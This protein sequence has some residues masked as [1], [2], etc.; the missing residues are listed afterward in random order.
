MRIRWLIFLA[1]IERPLCDIFT[2][3]SPARIHEKNTRPY[4]PR[5]L[6]CRDQVSGHILIA[7]VASHESYAKEFPGKLLDC[8]EK[9]G[10]IPIA[11]R[12]RKEET[13]ELLAEVAKRLKIEAEITPFLPGLEEALRE[14][15]DSF[16]RPPGEKNR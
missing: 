2:T 5:L 11:I 4:F 9:F 8:M 7:H 12:T 16:G 3:Y 13:L 1:A 15:E 10:M 6:L 14:I